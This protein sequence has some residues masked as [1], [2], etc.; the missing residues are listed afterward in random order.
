MNA[1]TQTVTVLILQSGWERARG[2]RIVRTKRVVVRYSIVVE[3]LER[4]PSNTLPLYV[5][6][7]EAVSLTPCHA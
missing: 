5:E 2:V 7:D 6:T 4:K 1:L 3:S